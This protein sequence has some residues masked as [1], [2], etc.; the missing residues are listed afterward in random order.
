M[1]LESCVA[2]SNGTNGVRTQGA[3][4]SPRINISN[5]Y[6]TGNTSSG[7]SVGTGSVKSFGNNHNDSNPGGNGAPTA[8][9]LGL[10]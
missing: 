7:I 5:V 2:S 10:Q 8:P 3:G 1:N 6:I 4:S 9:N